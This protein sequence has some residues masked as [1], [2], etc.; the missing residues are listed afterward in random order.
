MAYDTQKPSINW[1]P[2]KRVTVQLLD[3]NMVCAIILYNDSYYKNAWDLISIIW[4]LVLTLTNK[5]DGR[6]MLLL[7]VCPLIAVYWRWDIEDFQRQT[8]FDLPT[9]MHCKKTGAHN[10]LQM[11]QKLYGVYVVKSISGLPA[12]LLDPVQWDVPLMTCAYIL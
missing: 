6:P 8:M 11:G 7:H 3:P 2:Q 1:L 10:N 12:T 9:N 4:L 5:K